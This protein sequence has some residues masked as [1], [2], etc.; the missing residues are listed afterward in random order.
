M[1]SLF[2]LLRC[3]RQGEWKIRKGFVWRII[4]SAI[5]AFLDDTKKLANPSWELANLGLLEEGRMTTREMGTSGL[6]F[7]SSERRSSSVSF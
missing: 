6:L 2:S 7:L 5:S 1:K 3:T 4:L